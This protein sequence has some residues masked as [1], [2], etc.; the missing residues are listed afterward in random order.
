M[1]MCHTL[2]INTLLC[3]LNESLTEDF[4]RQILGYP[5]HLKFVGINVNM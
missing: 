3:L 1:R 4:P 5:I 2:T